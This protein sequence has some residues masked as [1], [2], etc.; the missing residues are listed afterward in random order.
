MAVSLV[1][2]Y[3]TY[4]YQLNRNS[5]VSPRYDLTRG[6][7]NHQT[8]PRQARA[9]SSHRFLSPAPNTHAQG[10]PNFRTR[11]VPR[12]PTP[13]QPP[14]LMGVGAL[15][16]GHTRPLSAQRPEH[17]QH[18]RRE[19]AHLPSEVFFRGP[20]TRRNQLLRFQEGEWFK[21]NNIKLK[22]PEWTFNHFCG[23][24]LGPRGWPP[25]R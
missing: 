19:G 7:V 20:G 5:Q 8:R 12:D 10:G 6:R 4:L 14:P 18:T 9:M 16:R 13:T 3:F 23:L 24:R 17:S 22:N 11:A 15:G 2:I 21:T 25:A 1:I